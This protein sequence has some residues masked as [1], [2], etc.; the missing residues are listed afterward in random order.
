MNENER[1]QQ[2]Y[3]QEIIDLLRSGEDIEKLQEKLEEYHANDIA[4]AL[5]LL[6]EDER[7]ILYNALENE[8]LG[9]VMEY[10]EHGYLYLEEMTSE[11]AAI[12]LSEMEP[13]D[14]VD[15]LKEANPE[16]KTIWLSKMSLKDRNE[17]QIL[18]AYDESF[19][20]SR[21]TTN[22]VF[23]DKNLSIRE[24]MRSLIEQAAEHDNI[25]KVYVV[26]EDGSY[27]GAVDLKELIIARK[28]T[29]LDDIT[30]TGYPFVYAD[31]K[32]EDCLERI[33]GYAENSIPVLGEN[34]I[35]L[36]VITAQDVLEVYDDEMG[37]D[38]ARLG[39]LTAEE[40]LNEPLIDSVKKRLPWLVIL[41]F[42]GLVVSTVV[43]LFETVVAQLTIIMAFQSLILDMSG[44]VGTQSL[45]VTI[46]VLMDERLTGKQKMSLVGKEMAVGGLNGLVIGIFSLVGIGA[47]LFFFKHQPAHIAIA[48]SSC[49]GFS[50]ML[51]MVISSLVGTV[52]PIFFKKVGVDPAAAS[53]PLITTINDLVGVVS[54]YGLTWILLL[55]I[56]KIS[57]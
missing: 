11:R 57:G 22:F 21:M 12:I 46:R 30:E 34:N 10:A 32:I 26:N 33:K 31:E 44:N 54:Y 55:E 28:E 36:G 42:L 48:I 49:I 53:G 41:L 1:V 47:Y 52:T 4:S 35:I 29:N 23:L 27:Y 38:Y 15:L 2:D 17:L 14:A 24:A 39:G 8:R 5:P 51:S 43:G 19:I 9:E 18:A 56:L 40:D 13:D 6:E 3:V 7:K 37:E 50:L 25:S 45:A 20:G 16:K